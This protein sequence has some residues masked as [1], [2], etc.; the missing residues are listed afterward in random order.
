MAVQG[1]AR[2]RRRRNRARFSAP[3]IGRFLDAVAVLEVLADLLSGGVE[4]LLR[5]DVCR[6]GA[7]SAR[8]ANVLPLV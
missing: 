4:A 6:L 7:T 8:A 5:A 3:C 1:G 2:M